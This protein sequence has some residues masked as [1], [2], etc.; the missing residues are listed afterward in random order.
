MKQKLTHIAGTITLLG[1]FLLAVDVC[2][3]TPDATHIAF[4]SR[5]TGN[6]D[7]Y[8]MDIEGKNIENFTNHPSWDFSPTFSP[9]G[10]WMAYVSD[11]DIYL[12]NLATKERQRLTE[13]RSP[14]WSPDGE[15]IVFTSSRSGQSNIYK[16][17]VNGEEVQQLTDE[18]SNGNPSWSPDGESIIFNSNRD[19]GIFLSVYVMT[20]D[21]RRQ[22]RLADG[23]SPVWSPDGKQ[24]AYILGIAGSGVY[25][26]NAE[27]KN[28]RRLTP[29]KTW[30]ESPAWSPDGQW[31]AYESELENPWGNLNRDSNIYLISPIGGKSRRLTD[32]PALDSFPAWVPAGFLS[33]SPTANTQ[34][35]LWGALKK[36][37]SELN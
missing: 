32:H 37:G 5:R 35:T 1:C 27:G 21:G 30:S 33:V 29:E 4:T 31:I 36:S 3:Q 25:V 16:I 24:I 6:S 14:D 12:M 20:A 23:S 10:R 13:G 15:S 18:A 7:I 34:T 28:S 2:G 26:M 9:N 11:K 8:I 17:D 22:R 19:G